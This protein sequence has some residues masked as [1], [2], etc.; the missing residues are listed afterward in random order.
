MINIQRIG[1]FL[2]LAENLSFSEA[3]KQRHL[4]RPTVS[5]HIRT[6][7]QELGVTLFERS[8]AGLRLTETAPQREYPLREVFNGLG[9]M[10]RAGASWRMLPND[11]PPWHV[12]YDQTHRWLKAGVFAALVQDL[13]ALLR[14]AHGRDASPSAAILDSR[15]FG[16]AGQ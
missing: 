14:L 16:H 9:W 1:T 13:R 8:G 5:H 7:E 2:S 12:V 3:A 11:L 10:V 4:S 6:L 15:T